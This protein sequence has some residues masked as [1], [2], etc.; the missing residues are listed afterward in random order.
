MIQA[1]EGPTFYFI[2]VTTAG[3][4][5]MKLF[6]QW[7]EAAGW[8]AT[9][10]RGYDIEVRGPREAYRRIVGHIREDDKAVSYTHLRAHET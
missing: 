3:S 9:A 1:L 7:L 6:P 2:G 4:L 5:S 10:I 8:P